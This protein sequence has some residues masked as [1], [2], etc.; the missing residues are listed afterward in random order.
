MFV[1]LFILSNNVLTKKRSVVAVGQDVKA[2]NGT[3]PPFINSP[4][5][6]H[7]YPGN[8]LGGTV[9]GLWPAA[10]INSYG[11]VGSLKAHLRLCP[12]SIVRL[13]SPVLSRQVVCV[14]DNEWCLAEVVDRNE[15]YTD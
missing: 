3:P 12:K 11:T 14:M 13:L 5:N 4:Q 9:K 1:C 15:L 2:M 8:E 10:V 6:S 7:Y